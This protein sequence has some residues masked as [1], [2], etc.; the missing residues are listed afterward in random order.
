MNEARID[1][2][3]MELSLAPSLRLTQNCTGCGHPLN[4]EKT[5]EELSIESQCASAGEQNLP[6]WNVKRCSDCGRIYREEK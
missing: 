5:M 4:D 2:L 6:D 3:K 1:K